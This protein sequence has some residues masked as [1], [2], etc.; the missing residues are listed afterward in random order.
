MFARVHYQIQDQI[1]RFIHS[2]LFSEPQ[3]AY[4]SP[5]FY[6]K[7]LAGNPIT[8]RTKGMQN[9][10]KTTIIQVFRPN[11]TIL[12]LHQGV[13]TN[14]TRKTQF[15]GKLTHCDTHSR[16]IISRRLIIKAFNLQN[17]ISYGC[18]LMS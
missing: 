18:I 5:Y 14:S 1:N 7:A 4:D 2:F 11:N 13:A 8:H 10:D 12:F 3:N 15:S 16:K 6:V 17:P 9:R